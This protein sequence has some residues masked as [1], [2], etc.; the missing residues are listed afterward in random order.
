MKTRLTAVSF[1]LAMAAA[2]FLLVGPAYSGSAGDRTTHATLAEVNGSW[3]ILPV[4]FPVLTALVPLIFRKQAVRIFA[5]IFMG[6]FALIGGF[7][8]GLFYL[9]AAITMLLATCATPSAKDVRQ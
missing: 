7:S 8:I 1:G 3:I 6:G 4:M 5:T 9:P 2:I